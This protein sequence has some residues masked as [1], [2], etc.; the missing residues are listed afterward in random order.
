[1][2]EPRSL[3]E[4]FTDMWGSSSHFLSL[5]SSANDPIERLKY[6]VAFA[7]SGI[8]MSVKQSKPFNPILGETYEGYWPDGS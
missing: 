8:H 2:S 5:A 7:I 1:M 4:R 3:L 6:V